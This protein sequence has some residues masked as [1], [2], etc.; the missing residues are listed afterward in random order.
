MFT[1]E[2]LK[3]L[4]PAFTGILGLFI[5]YF[6][7][8][9]LYERKRKD[10]LDDRKF[11]IQ[12]DVKKAKIEEVQS[13][14][15]TSMDAVQKLLQYQNAIILTGDIVQYKTHFHN[16]AELMDIKAK[17]IVNVN[18]LDDIELSKLD[19]ELLS[20]LYVEFNKVREIQETIIKGGNLDRAVQL[21]RAAEFN[22]KAAE[23][24]GKMYRRL[25]IISQTIS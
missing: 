2:N 13:Y 23:L 8:Q 7:N 15:A 4:V 24:L 22:V 10:E 17:K 9:A 19:D 18:L 3:I 16:I 12:Y 11:N 25:H 21:Q 1:E 6:L 14:L 20:L 5:G